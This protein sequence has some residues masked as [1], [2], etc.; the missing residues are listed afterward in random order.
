VVGATTVANGDY[1]A[2][3]KDGNSAKNQGFIDLGVLTGDN[4][5]MALGLN[6][7]G[8]SVGFSKNTTTGAQRAVVWFNNATKYDLITKA[9]NASG[10]TS[11]NAEAINSSGWIVGWGVKSG[12][13]RAF[14]LVPNY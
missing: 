6:N 7:T 12:L 4:Y 5:S 13:Y 2:F 10:W 9:N 3:W 11:R 8:H 14:L 1:H